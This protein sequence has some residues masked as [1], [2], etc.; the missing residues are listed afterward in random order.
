[1]NRDPWSATVLGGHSPIVI[2]DHT[3]IFMRGLLLTD[4]MGA[5]PAGYRSPE[6]GADYSHSVIEIDCD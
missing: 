1:M 3:Q 4:W 2:R 6:I 5:E